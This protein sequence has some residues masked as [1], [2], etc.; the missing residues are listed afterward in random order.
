MRLKVAPN[1]T[2]CLLLTS[3]WFLMFVHP[4]LGL[5]CTIELVWKRMPQAFRVTVTNNGEPVTSISVAVT[6]WNED[7]SVERAEVRRGLTNSDGVFEVEGLLPGKYVVSVGEETALGGGA[8]IEVTDRSTW[9][10]PKVLPVSW[11]D[12]KVLVVQRL[13]G[14]LHW[15][16]GSEGEST[17]SVEGGTLTVK[18]ARSGREVSSVTVTSDGSFDAGN[19][20]KGLYAVSLRLRPNM[21]KPASMPF[22][23]WERLRWEGTLPVLIE[24]EQPTTQKV[25]LSLGYTSCGMEFEARLIE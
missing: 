17:T 2:C 8:F 22:S 16:A 25:Q 21:A 18:E 20:P 4:P 11:P 14:V 19:L 9:R 12:E 6:S 13:A 3:L 7:P 5:G 15:S 10:L 23:F 24:G 1:R